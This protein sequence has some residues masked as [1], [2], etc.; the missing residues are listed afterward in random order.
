MIIS[1]NGYQDR[2]FEMYLAVDHDI[3]DRDVRK[4]ADKIPITII[5]IASISIVGIL[6][7]GAIFYLLRKRKRI[8]ESM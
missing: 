8:S 2:H 5:I 4:P 6:G 3:L 7:G 1:A